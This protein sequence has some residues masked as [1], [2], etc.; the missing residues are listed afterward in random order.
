MA[1]LARSPWTCTRLVWKRVRGPAA[2]PA[3]RR[4]YTRRRGAGCGGRVLAF[5]ALPPSGQGW[6]WKSAWT[7]FTLLALANFLLGLACR[8]LLGQGNV[9]VRPSP[10]SDHELA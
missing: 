7:A 3:A 5:P 8:Y 6:Q 1:P 2:G 4:L 9:V 10:T